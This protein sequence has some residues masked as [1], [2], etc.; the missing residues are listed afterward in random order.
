MILAANVAAELLAR[1]EH[2]FSR[3]VALHKGAPRVFSLL[4]SFQTLSTGVIMLLT[5][6]ELSTSSK[7]SFAR[8]Y[9]S[10][11]ASWF[12]EAGAQI[13]VLMLLQ[14]VTPHI[15]PLAQYFH[16][17]RLRRR[18]EKREQLASDD[19]K[20]YRG[21][22]PQEVFIGPEFPMEVRLS[23]VILTVTLVLMYS[24]GLPM[25]YVL[26][27][28]SL[29]AA[30]WLDKYFILH[31]YRPQRGSHREL[32]DRVFSQTRVAFLLHFTI[33]CFMYSN[34]RILNDGEKR[35]KLELGAASQ[36]VS[37]FRQKW[38]DLQHL[39]IFILGNFLLLLGLL[40]GQPLVER[41]LQ[42]SSTLKASAKYRDDYLEVCSVSYFFEEYRRAVVER[43]AFKSYASCFPPGQVRQLATIGQHLERLDDKIQSIEVRIGDL[44]AALG[45]REPAFE[46]RVDR[47]KQ[48]KEQVDAI[49]DTELVGKL[50]TYDVKANA[51]YIGVLDAES[52]TYEEQQAYEERAR[53]AG[54]AAHARWSN[55]RGSLTLTKKQPAPFASA[56]A[57]LGSTSAHVNTSA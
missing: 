55:L 21:E 18:E 36:F 46:A 11:S 9:E 53:A 35:D 40:I 27:I 38:Y 28:G 29:A 10:F 13:Q 7:D 39:Q 51:K 49:H 16:H 4:T 23:Q 2:L 30:F 17:L 1:G 48:L 41:R 44:C 20:R 5:H 6:L 47:L 45:V 14:A 42:G 33:G 54:K 24:P 26:G 25:L 43:V 57:A 15:V 31:F 52:S 12:F 3:P 34:G 22:E 8:Y 37:A 32:L 56:V 19:G 50:E